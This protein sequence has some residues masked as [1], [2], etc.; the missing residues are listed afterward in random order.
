MAR[1]LQN[2]DGPMDHRLVIKSGPD[3]SEW[4]VSLEDGVR[5]MAGRSI[6]ESRTKMWIDSER[7]DE[8]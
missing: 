7:K 6:Y 4:P 5:L 2:G 8:T 1:L 3:H